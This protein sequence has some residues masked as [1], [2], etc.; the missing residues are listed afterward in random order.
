MKGYING[1]YS[2]LSLDKDIPTTAPQASLGIL[3]KT[4]ADSKLSYKAGLH[5]YFGKDGSGNTLGGELGLRYDQDDSLH[6]EVTYAI[7]KI[8]IEYEYFDGYGI[9]HSLLINPLVQGISFGVVKT[10][11]LDS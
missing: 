4:D 8:E 3:Y 11:S 10:L 5:T 2:V 6:Y 1:K 7:D 9:Q